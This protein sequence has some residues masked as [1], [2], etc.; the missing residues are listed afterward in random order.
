LYNF[1]QS[2]KKDGITPVSDK[3]LFAIY[4]FFLNNRCKTDVSSIFLLTLHYT[5][6]ATMSLSSW[7]MADEAWAHGETRPWNFAINL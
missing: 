3:G 6:L 1:V 4:Y 7:G 5:S 2:Y